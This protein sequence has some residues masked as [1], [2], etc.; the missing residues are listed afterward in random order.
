M[1]R[2][3]RVILSE[4]KV[5]IPNNCETPRRALLNGRDVDDSLIKEDLSHGRGGDCYDSFQ[6][7]LFGMS[8]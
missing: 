7:C 5:Q 4:G 2:Y 8:S 6:I 1:L 3:V